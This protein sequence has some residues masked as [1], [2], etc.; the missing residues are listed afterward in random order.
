[1]VT[2]LLS[3]WQHCLNPFTMLPVKGSFETGLI[4]HIS[5]H[6]FRSA[7]FQKEISYEAYL[8]FEN[9]LNFMQISKMQEKIGKNYCLSE[10]IASELVTLN[11]L[12]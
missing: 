9:V 1:M 2:V 6:V 3:R 8:F 11:C 4:G 10:I 7:Q 12:Y 5:S